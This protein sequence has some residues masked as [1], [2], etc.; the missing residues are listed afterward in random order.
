MFTKILKYG[1]PA[2]ALSLVLALLL[3]AP[4]TQ[5]P[6]TTLNAKSA[7]SDYTYSGDQLLRQIRS[8]AIKVKGHA[9][10]MQSLV[11]TP[12]S[13]HWLTHAW[14]LTQIKGRVNHMGDS[15]VRLRSTD[16]RSA[17][18]LMGF[19]TALVGHTEAAIEF[20]K[21]R[22]FARFWDA[23][24]KGHVDGIYRSADQMASA[25]REFTREMASR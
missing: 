2:V 16:S 18:N 14:Y 25:T 3:G 7:V 23:G 8:D 20:S 11:R 5:S 19:Q 17:P 21:A 22:S 9:D 10:V 4:R 13:F 12:A 1:Y 15:L 6:I 24:Y